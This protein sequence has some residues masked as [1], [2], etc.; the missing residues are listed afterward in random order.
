MVSSRLQLQFWSRSKNFN[1]EKTTH[2]F[3]EGPLL[4]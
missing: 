2:D 1:R 4:S 3:S